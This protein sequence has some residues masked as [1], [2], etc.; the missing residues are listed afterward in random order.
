M[1]VSRKY[2]YLFAMRLKSAR[3]IGDIESS[4]YE[5]LGRRFHA[6]IPGLL[7]RVW[8]ITNATSSFADPAW[9]LITGL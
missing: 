3:V 2:A 9:T 4:V 6:L 7:Y 1:I 8:G 5:T